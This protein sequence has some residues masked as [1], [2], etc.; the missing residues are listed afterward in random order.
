M[1]KISI[2]KLRLPRYIQEN[3][4]QVQG[5]DKLISFFKKLLKGVLQNTEHE[6]TEDGHIISFEIMSKKNLIDNK[7][8]VNHGELYVYVW[9]KRESQEI[10]SYCI[11]RSKLSNV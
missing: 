3:V 10:K 11:M 7:P 1:E 6:F 8:D 2:C 4:Q 5:K 9:R